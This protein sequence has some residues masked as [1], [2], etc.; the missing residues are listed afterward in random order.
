MKEIIKETLRDVQVGWTSQPE[1][2]KAVPSGPE[3][4]GRKVEPTASWGL[5]FLQMEEGT[6]IWERSRPL[7]VFTQRRE[8]HAM[9][10]GV[11]ERKQA[12]KHHSG[13]LCGPVVF[14]L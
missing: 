8:A 4:W 6:T 13:C 12:D 14:P 7:A 3:L 11:R 2:K 1:G 10:T 5:L 9:S